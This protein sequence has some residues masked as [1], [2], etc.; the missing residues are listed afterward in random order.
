MLAW[1]VREAGSLA[2]RMSCVPWQSVQVAATLLPLLRDVPCT[3]PLYSFTACSWQ[4]AQL[5]GFSLSACG[6]LSAETSVWQSVHL[7]LTLPCTDVTNFAPSTAIDLPS[8]PLASAAEWHMRQVSLTDG[9]AVVAAALGLA[10]A[11]KA[12]MAHMIAPV[13]RMMIGFIGCPA[14]LRMGMR[15]GD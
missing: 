5:T 3:V 1:L 2:R 8:L 10:W 6:I 11:A 14:G 7:R 4:V 9:G 12:R 13:A 15:S